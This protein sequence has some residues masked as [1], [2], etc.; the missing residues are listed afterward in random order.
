MQCTGRCGWIRHWAYLSLLHVVA[1]LPVPIVPKV[2]PPTKSR[3][4]RL[5]L[6]CKSNPPP[7]LQAL[8]EILFNNTYEDVVSVAGNTPRASATTSSGLAI[9]VHSGQFTIDI[10]REECFIIKWRKHLEFVSN[11]FD[12][13]MKRFWVHVSS[14]PT[15]VV[16]VV[17]SNCLLTKCQDLFW[18]HSLALAWPTYSTWSLRQQCT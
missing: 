18:Y 16:V 9:G 4:H 12:S 2:L 7:S 1:E 8:G 5:L 17:F 15:F 10:V 11:E 14:S 13:N 6:I 3:L